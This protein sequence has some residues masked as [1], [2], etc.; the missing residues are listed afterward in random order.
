M[1]VKKYLWL[2]LSILTIVA[3]ED[4]EDTY[5]DYMGD[6]TIRYVGICTD[7]TITPG[8]KRLIVKWK[9]TP[10]LLIDKIEVK[11]KKDEFQDSV[12]LEPD[13]TEYNITGLEEGNYEVL[14]YG[15]DEEGN[16][17]LATPLLGRP[18]TS[19]HE[20]I[21]S[22]TRLI[23][24]HYFLKDRLILFF[25]GWSDLVESAILSYYVEGEDEA[26]TLELNADL[27]ACKYYLLPDHINPNKPVIL[28][29][30][31]RVEGCEDLIVFDSYELSHEKLYT[32]DFKW[33]IREK[34]GKSEIDENFVKELNVLEIDYT[35]TSF[36]DILNL[37]NLEVLRL[38]RNRYLQEAYLSST[39]SASGLYELEASLFALN[40]AHEV[41]GLKVERYN[42]H[43][44]P[45]I[46]LPYIQE[47]GNPV[48]PEIICMDA[49]DWDVTCIP[50]DGDA[51]N[52]RLE[53]LF[54][55][56]LN[57]WWQ[58][59][60]LPSART[61]EILVDMKVN[62]AL[63]GV[64]IV[65]KIFNPEDDEMSNKLL[66]SMIKIQISDDKASWKNITYVEEN[67]IG[68]TAGEISIIE[69][70]SLQRGRYLK[71]VVYDQVYGS[72]FTV[73]L[74]EIGIF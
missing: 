50:K 65:Q 61:H 16:H 62:N 6:G 44:L 45:E 66:P 52:S 14:V 43:F 54:D 12:L 69:F 67:T 1:M 59:E 3:C 73:A 56:N 72:N 21:L 51:W 49:S 4:L 19:T 35:I 74:A 2:L 46:T 47:M 27:I 40:V 63:R 71:F 24:K 64:K 18:Y 10:D 70:P 29:R 38:G 26:R 58:P 28:N 30:K 42:K 36:E 31:G 7:V 33:L 15:V 9:N 13:Q 17:S 32:S 5:S 68:A 60:N 11:W 20:T 34:Y 22:F 41:Y 25:S 39:G 23:A 48:L 37:P 57:N 53:S 55:G 8:W